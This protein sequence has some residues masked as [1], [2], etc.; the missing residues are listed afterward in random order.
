MAAVTITSPK[1]GEEFKSN[2]PI[3]VTGTAVSEVNTIALYS[4]FGGTSFLL[5]KVPVTNGK[6]TAQVTFNT[7]GQR[8]IIADGLDISDHSRDFDPDEVSILIEA[9]FT[10][11][12]KVGIVTSQFG[13]RGGRIHKGIDIAHTKG[14]PVFAVAD[15]KVTYVGRGCVEGDDACEGGFGNNID[16]THSA[17]GLVSLYA[18]LQTVEVDLNQSV[19]KG[20]RIGTMGNTGRSTGPHLHFEIRRSGVPLNPE[21]FIKPI[22]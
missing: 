21:D 13:P 7:G 9:G 14:T 12:V 10:K 20:Q 6:W 2:T 19:S 15:G 1:D 16:I 11:P 18:H 5:A 4:P 22:V 8:R 17:L 3:T